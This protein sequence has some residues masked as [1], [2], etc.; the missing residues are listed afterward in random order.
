MSQ[1]E[2]EAHYAELK[3]E[4]EALEEELAHSKARQHFAHVRQRIETL[5][6][7]LRESHLL[8][9]TILENSAASIYA[10]RKDGRYI[11]L[12]RG[13]EILCNVTREQCLGRTDVDVF[14]IE[15]A[16]Q[17]RSNDL[18]AMMTGKLLESEETTKTP[19]GERRVLAR[20]VPL[21]SDSGEVEGICG[22]STDITDLRRTELALRE[23]V[24]TLQRERDNKLLNV[25]AATASLAHEVR[26]PLTAISAGGV[27]AMRFLEMSPPDLDEVRAIL[28][29]I[30]TNCRHASEVFDSISALFKK[31]DQSRRPVDVNE[32]SLSVLQS[33]HGQLKDH[34]VAIETEL[35]SDLPLVDG[36][37]GQLRQVVFNLVHNAIEA[38]AT[39]TDRARL[40]RVSTQPQGHNAIVVAV[41]DSGPG[42]DPGRLNSIFDAFVT[43]KAN[44]MG[45]GLAICRMIVQRHGGRLSASSDG[46]AGARLQFVLPLR[47][48]DTTH[49]HNISH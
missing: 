25:E 20:K 34:S 21:I 26:Q 1:P 44:G 12:N 2:F 41:E 5:Y 40:L 35:A 37:Q 47:S 42:I 4:I 31:V 29:Q 27:A 18:T 23:A 17:Y 33:V 10:K 13:M 30:V 46:R 7:T 32:I 15:I 36:H 39:T 6:E 48:A 28:D 43:T 14:P 49:A 24:E 19:A 8:L 22:I 11:Y 3:R 9:H 16:E 38:M 45:L